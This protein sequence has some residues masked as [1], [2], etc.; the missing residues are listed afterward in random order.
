MIPVRTAR[1]LAV[2]M[3]VAVASLAGCSTRSKAESSA[4]RTAGLEAGGEADHHGGKGEEGEDG[5]GHTEPTLVDPATGKQGK[6]R[7]TD[8]YSAVSPPAPTFRDPD[9]SGAEGS[10]PLTAS[11][12]PACV[13][14]GQQLT[15]VLKSEPGMTVVAQIKWPNEQ[16]SG[17]DSTRATTGPDGLHTWVVDVKPTALYGVS[18]LQAAAIDE[19]PGHQSRSGSQGSWQFVVAPPG[20]C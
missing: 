7:E 11:T 3:L 20:R 8:R 1:V 19:R 14:H 15:V 4:G 6:I 16:F 13:E 9:I 10:V 5:H 2:V 18:D 17:L 12:S